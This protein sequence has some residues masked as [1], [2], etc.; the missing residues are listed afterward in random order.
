MSSAVD[1]TVDQTKEN[2]IFFPPDTSE[3]KFNQLN[4]QLSTLQI[5]E[6]YNKQEIPVVIIKPL[7]LI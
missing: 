6:T 2:H 4:S 1:Q 3:E 5:L 7:F